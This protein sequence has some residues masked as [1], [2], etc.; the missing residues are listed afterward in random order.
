MANQ[1]V[2]PVNKVPDNDGPLKNKTGLRFQEEVN[3]PEV[4]GLHGKMF[5]GTTYATLFSELWETEQKL[6]SV[7]I[8]N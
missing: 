7:S 1:S 4:F 6:L 3:M 2:N 5:C 8:N